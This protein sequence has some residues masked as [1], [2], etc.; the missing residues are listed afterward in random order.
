LV[1]HPTQREVNSVAWKSRLAEFGAPSWRAFW[2]VA[3][4]H[5][6][7]WG[8]T[9]AVLLG[10][11]WLYRVAGIE[12]MWIA[13]GAIIL[14][15]LWMERRVPVY[16]VEDVWWLGERLPPASTDALPPPGPRQ[17]TSQHRR[18]LPKR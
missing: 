17:I 9:L 3:A 14:L 11:V 7:V 6:L 15:A 4:V 12:A 1:W 10:V 18:A 2:L 16:Y 8:A 5:I 13:V